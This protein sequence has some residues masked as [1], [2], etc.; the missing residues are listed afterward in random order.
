MIERVRRAERALVFG[1]G[2]HVLIKYFQAGNCL[3]YGHF[4]D[5]TAVGF[6]FG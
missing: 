6:D 1:H 3:A 4:V 2:Q 5:K